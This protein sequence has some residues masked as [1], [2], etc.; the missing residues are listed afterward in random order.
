[1]GC[2]LE[3]TRYLQFLNMNNNS[4]LSEIRL[5]DLCHDTVTVLSP[6]PFTS[7][8]CYKNLSP[9]VQI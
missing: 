1:M 2:N 8:T 5:N 7:F 3:K 9:A 4:G 6:V